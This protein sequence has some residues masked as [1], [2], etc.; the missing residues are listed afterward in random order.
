MDEVE[1]KRRAAVEMRRALG[2]LT[3]SKDIVV[4]TP[5]EIARRG[6]VVGGHCLDC[7]HPHGLVFLRL[8]GRVR[9]VL[10]NDRL[11]RVCPRALEYLGCLCSRGRVWRE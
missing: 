11:I 6:N 5:A 8:C 9:G 2:D 7:L 1:N 4:T 3:V 10:R